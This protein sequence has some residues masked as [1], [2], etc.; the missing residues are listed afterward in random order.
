MTQQ[1]PP[2][3]RFHP[4]FDNADNA[5]EYLAAAEDGLNMALAAPLG[6]KA[7]AAHAAVAG[8]RATIGVGRYLAA[9]L[10]HLDHPQP[11]A[12]TCTATWEPR[13]AGSPGTHH[14]CRHPHGHTGAH[15]SPDG[16]ARWIDGASGAEHLHSAL[17]TEPAPSH[18][19]PHVD[20]NSGAQCTR[21]P[22]HTLH[23][24]HGTIM[25]TPD[26]CEAASITG[27][28]KWC[29]LASN[30]EGAHYFQFASGNAGRCTA[31]EPMVNGG[32]R[33]CALMAGHNRDHVTWHGIDWAGPDD[34]PVPIHPETPCTVP[35]IPGTG[36]RC[37]KSDGHTGDHRYVDACDSHSNRGHRC[38]NSEPGHQLHHDL[39]GRTWFVV[40]GR[41]VSTE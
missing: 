1:R 25:W 16:D 21:T 8:T 11:P 22:G 36:R 4:G 31:F 3:T 37:D 14:A 30:H 23:H 26:P 7:T 33:L 34:T 12:G 19:C 40:E 18:H 41:S 28:D 39:Y 6:D 5:A 17:S 38:R 2:G 35:G 24:A 10:N 29:I 27:I 9:I 13:R 32:I 20:P 15:E